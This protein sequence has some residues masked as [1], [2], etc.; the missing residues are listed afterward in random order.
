MSGG[1][2]SAGADLASLSA[3]LTAKARRLAQARLASSTRP[4]DPAKW[5]KASLLW[6]LFGQE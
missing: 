4:H 5:R 6:P 2:I 3:R 1:W